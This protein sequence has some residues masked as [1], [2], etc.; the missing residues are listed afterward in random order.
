MNAGP[1][2][3]FSDCTV[4]MLECFLTAEHSSANANLTLYVYVFFQRMWMA[5]SSTKYMQLLSVPY[6]N[7]FS[8]LSNYLLCFYWFNL[9]PNP[10]FQY[11]TIKIHYKNIL[12]FIIMLFIKTRIKQAISIFFR[13]SLWCHFQHK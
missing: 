6:H 13:F 4:S 9:V 10:D 12:F 8:N 5:V 3:T 7:L 1:A 11:W 2:L